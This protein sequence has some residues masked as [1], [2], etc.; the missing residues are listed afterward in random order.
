MEFHQLRYFVAAAECLNISRAAEKVHVSQP[1]LSRQ[2]RLLEEELGADLFRRIRKRI[3]LSEAGRVFLPRARGILAQAAEA[4]ALMRDKFAA[5][6]IIRFGAITPFLDDLVAPALQEYAR[7]HPQTEVHV[8]DAAPSELIAKLRRGDLDLA[9]LGNL[10]KKDRNKFHLT[11]LYEHHHAAVLPAQHPMA[12]RR[13]LRLAELALDRWVSLS[14]NHFPGRRKFLISACRQA[15]FR[16]VIISE[17][18]SIPTLI[19]AVK[20]RQAVAILPAHC[21]KFPHA[22]CAFV[23]LAGPLIKSS[24][25]LVRATRSAATDSDELAEILRSTAASM[26]T[27]PRPRKPSRRSRTKRAVAR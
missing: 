12:G 3:F 2:L 22:G 15:G 19:A 27:V 18:D 8:V 10:E 24:L 16:P 7:R 25:L 6:G 4:A 20:V 13:S 23:G 11:L 14:D 5:R 1:A 21:A 17:V 26:G 9:V